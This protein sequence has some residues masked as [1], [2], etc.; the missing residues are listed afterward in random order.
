[1]K[2]EADQ[3]S[4]SNIQLSQLENRAFSG[5]IPLINPCCQTVTDIVSEVERASLREEPDSICAENWKAGK[6]LISP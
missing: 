1:M 4:Q 6:V 5:R 2:A 3:K